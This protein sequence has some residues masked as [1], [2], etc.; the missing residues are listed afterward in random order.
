MNIAV[1]SFDQELIKEISKKLPDFQVKG[2][3]DSLSLLRDIKFFNPDVII[4]DASGGE[5]ALNALEFFISR[6]KIKGKPIKV[7]IS[8]DNPIDESTLSRFKELEFYDKE[9]EVDKLTENL[10][11]LPASVGDLEDSPSEEVEEVPIEDTTIQSF[12]EHYQPPADMEALIGDGGSGDGE[13]ELSSEE[14]SL[15]EVGEILKEMEYIPSEPQEQEDTTVKAEEVLETSA[16]Q[17][18]QTELTSP[19]GEENLKITIELSPEEVRKTVLEIAVERLIDEIKN[20]V[21]I[22]KIKEDLQKDF[23]DR[24]EKELKE[25][26]EEI[27]KSIKEKLLESIE[28]DLKEKIRESIKEDVSKITTELVKEKLSQVFGEK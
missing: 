22:Q 12:E 28:S 18:S 26:V 19:Q 9:T 16:F 2:Y 1:I 11:N 13:I 17:S 14:S 4:Y 8:K 5:L 10:K 7:L 24:L 20:D 15:E 21:D 23:F 25:S 3:T 6:D 27:K